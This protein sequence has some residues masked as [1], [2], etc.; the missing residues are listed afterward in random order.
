MP[1]FTVEQVAA[2]RAFRLESARVERR[3]RL[4]VETVRDFERV[5]ES[6]SK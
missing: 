5:E 6:K 3:I 4:V 2:A 1:T